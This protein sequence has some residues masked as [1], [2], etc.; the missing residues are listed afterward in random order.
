MAHFYLVL[1]SLCGGITALQLFIVVPMDI[2]TTI[3]VK[4]WPALDA[5]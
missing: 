4:T 3:S 5:F 2:E 1:R